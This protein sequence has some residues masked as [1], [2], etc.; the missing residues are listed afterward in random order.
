M[1]TQPITNGSAARSDNLATDQPSLSDQ[2]MGAALAASAAK[3]AAASQT[4]ASQQGQ[5][6]ATFVGPKAGDA[7]GGPD[8][9]VDFDALV[10]DISSNPEKLFTAELTAEQILELQKRI[11]PYAFTPSSIAAAGDGDVKVRSVAASYTNLREDYIR[12]F[13]MTSLVGFIFQ[14]LDEW[15]VPPEVRRWVPH[16]RKKKGEKGS[17][18]VDE[19]SAPF[20]LSVLVGK[21]ETTLLIAKEA[22]N[23]KAE[24]EQAIQKAKEEAAIDD[25]SEAAA[26][27]KSVS[28]AAAAKAAGLLYAAT[29]TTCRIGLD[30]EKRLDATTEEA[31]KYPEVR[32]ILDKSSVRANSGAQIEMPADTAKGIIGNFLKHW[33]KF[34]PNIHVRAARDNRADASKVE[35]QTELGKVMSDKDDPARLPLDIVLAK[36]PKPTEEDKDYV[37]II[38]STREGYNAACRAL[39]DR[40][41][42][43]ALMYALLSDEN[44]DRFRRYL[45]PIPSRKDK[46]DTLGRA[47]AR[48]A[49]EVIPPQDTFHR[50]A[51]YTE[52]N[53]EELRVATECIYN[54][55]PDLDWAIGLW[56]IFEG[57][58]DEVKKQFD[59]YCER[60]QDEVPSIVRKLDVGS[61]SL[62]GDFKKSRENIK[63]YNKHTEVL[64][65][66]IDRH[67]EDKKLGAD[68][69]RKRVRDLKAKNIADS[70]PDAPGLKQYQKTATTVPSLGAEKVISA[71]EMRRLE[72]ARGDVKAARELEVLE[73]NEAKI[74]EFGRIAANRPLSQVETYELRDAKA[75]LEKALE[76]INV[77]ENALQVDCFTHDT[78]S[79]EFTKSHFFTQAEKPEHMEQIRREMAQ[80]S[81]GVGS[82]HPIARRQAA[83]TA[84]GRLPGILEEVGAKSGAAS[85]SKPSTDSTPPV[86]TSALI[87]AAPPANSAADISNL[88]PFAI[89]YMKLQEER[90]N[91]TRKA[92]AEADAASAAAGTSGGDK[93]TSIA[94]AADQTL[95][96]TAVQLPGSN[97]TVPLPAGSVAVVVESIPDP[98]P[99]AG[100]D[101][102]SA[103]TPSQVPDADA[104]DTV[105][106]Q[107]TT[108]AI[109][110][111]DAEG[112]P[113][114]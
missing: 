9:D 97:L 81:A 54:E 82:N 45:Y 70:G 93:K 110:T 16:P 7:A 48:K 13:T 74:I 36:A 69:M 34:D 105:A 4:A 17:T 6:M 56:E 15:T 50:W 51:Y 30:A 19:A 83:M 78:K 66:I 25:K 22:L 65:R 42:A 89:Q 106:P 103:A 2:E 94:A 87:Q 3:F 1:E 44:S 46:D 71:I 37:E 52:V 67:T 33:L 53:Y 102:Q 68:L 14:I 11:N 40:E 99:T 114:Q 12:R 92:E 73:Q 76:S 95:A 100:T 10:R 107:G 86:S 72:R 112:A 75:A 5:L 62:L 108:G 113:K 26:K 77:P 21:L 90:S 28:D 38:R 29:N 31:Y 91:A 104:K 80:Q 18:A 88:A 96:M 84:A 27:A 8:A 63:F 60:Y 43:A 98:A 24:A 61:W 35:T 59:A 85:G 109:P 49:V 41:L 79:G 64:K 32:D 20:D 101:V 23:A 39:G 111:V 55:K 58:E 57:P 47:E